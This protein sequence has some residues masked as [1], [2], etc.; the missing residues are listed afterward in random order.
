MD[1]HLRRPRIVTL[2]AKHIEDIAAIEKLCFSRPWSYEALAEE[3]SNPLAVF[4]VIE[5]DGKTVAYAGMHH[6]LDEGY[7]TN[8]AVHPDSR[9]QGLATAL[10]RAL[11][12]YADKN[13]LA[14]LTLEVRASNSAAIAIYRHAGFDEE[15]V[16]TGFYEDPIE[17]AL[18]MSKYY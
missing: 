18:I 7:I 15:G 2:Q 17:D 6:I 16:R 14:R 13:D 12:E 9:R 4:F 8:I 1:D 10:V 11:D 3:L 5:Q